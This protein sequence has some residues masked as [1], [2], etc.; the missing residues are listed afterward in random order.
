MSSWWGC[1]RRPA[2]LRRSVEAWFW[3][4]VRAFCFFSKVLK[5]HYKGPQPIVEGRHPEK[6]LAKV[7]AASS[8][9][10]NEDSR[11]FNAEGAGYPRVAE[12]AGRFASRSLAAP[13]VPRLSSA[14]RYRVSYPPHELRSPRAARAR[15]RDRATAD[16]APGRWNRLQDHEQRRLAGPMEQSCRLAAKRAR[17]LPLQGRPG[18][19]SRSPST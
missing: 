9:R 19:G 15:A 13:S 1:L 4:L 6:R 5:K 3:A 11:W 18:R 8:L 7:M 14:R 12:S 2:A 10:P 16:A 17:A